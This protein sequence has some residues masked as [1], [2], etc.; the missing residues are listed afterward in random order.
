MLPKIISLAAACSIFELIF[1]EMD[2]PFINCS[3][4]GERNS[5]FAPE[6]ASCGNFLRDKVANIDLFPTL[7]GLADDPAVTFDRIIFAENKNFTSFLFTFGV[8]KFFFLGY[9]ISFHFLGLEDDGILLIYGRF[10]LVLVLTLLLPYLIHAI[11]PSLRGTL[12]WRDIAAGFSYAMTPVALSALIM[13]FL[14]F[15]I[16]G[17]FLFSRN[18]SPADFKQMFGVIFL[19][20]EAGFL[21]WTVFLFAVFLGRLTGKTLLSILLSVIFI[22]LMFGLNLGVINLLSSQNL[23]IE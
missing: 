2:Q 6:C 5:R 10:M 4:C 8:L 19:L 11:L 17:S 7:S 22:M 15:V 9:L 21:I 18:P 1:N 16:Y 14:E 23:G 13:I 20:L 12:L 3:V